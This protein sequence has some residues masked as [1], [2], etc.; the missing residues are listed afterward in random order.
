M[1]Y[2]LGKIV[3]DNSKAEKYREMYYKNNDRSV[4]TILNAVC[5][6]KTFDELDEM[7]H[8]VF[9]DEDRKDF[10]RKFKESCCEE[11]DRI[12]NND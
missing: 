1:S 6:A 11:M 4:N 2:F 9:N 3:I 12:I 7:L 8:Y 10:L 5:A